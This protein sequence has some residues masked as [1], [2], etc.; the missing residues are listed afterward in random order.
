MKQME[1]CK[2]TVTSVTTTGFSNLQC[3]IN[4]FKLINVKTQYAGLELLVHE[5]GTRYVL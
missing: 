4:K 3:F 5:Y 2:T 1:G